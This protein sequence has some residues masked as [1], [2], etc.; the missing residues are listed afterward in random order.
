MERG[1]AEYL[2][3]T[4][5]PNLENHEVLSSQKNYRNNNDARQKEESIRV[6]LKDA[7]P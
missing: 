2:A 3:L 6:E 1:T 4:N 5:F 7:I